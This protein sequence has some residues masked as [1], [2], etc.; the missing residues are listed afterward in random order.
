VDDVATNDL[1]AERPPVRDYSLTG[2]RTTWAAEHG[3]VNAA[4]YR[5]DIPRKTLKGL[6]ERTDGPATRDTAL[7]LGLMGATGIGAILS[8][9]SWK[10]LP[11]LAAYGVLY[12]SGSDS[13]WHEMGHGTAFRDQRVNGAV[14]QLASFMLFRNPTVWR[15]S[16]ARHHT[17]TIIVGSDPEIIAQRPVRFRDLVYNVFPVKAHAQSLRNMVRYARGRVN[18]DERSFVPEGEIPKVVREARIQLSVLAGACA[19]AAGTRS[20]LP[21]LLVG[22]PA[23]YGGIFFQFFGLTQ[24]AG[25]AEDVL[26]HRLNTRT[27]RMNPVFRFLYSNMNYHT[28]HHMFPNVPYHAL[29]QLHELVKD[30]LPK[31]YANTWEAYREIIPA[32]WRQRTDPDHYVRLELPVR[33]PAALG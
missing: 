14:Y 16:H 6:M 3:L 29:P 15:W 27:V 4:W 33:A 17:D 26:D 20:V 12:G 13:R 8:W 9:R 31:V 10:S 5:P 23:V 25:L 30:D 1:L 24:H 18:A 7:W 11:F 28:E 2:P 32:L 22:F 21:L 19:V